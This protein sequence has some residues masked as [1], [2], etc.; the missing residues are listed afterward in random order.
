MRLSMW[1]IVDILKEYHPTVNIK[2][3]ERILRNVR[4][5]SDN[6]AISRSTVYLS[7]ISDKEILCSNEMDMVICKCRDLIEIFNTLMD[8]FEENAEWDLHI[9]DMIAD[10]CSL[11]ELLSEGAKR[12]QRYFFCADAT[13]Y[14]YKHCGDKNIIEHMP[15]FL[16]AVQ[17]NMLPIDT[18][19]EINQQKHIR[20]PNQKSYFIGI[21]NNTLISIVSNL[22]LR[23]KHSGWLV[24]IAQEPCQY[25]KG[26]CDQQDMFCD[27]VNKWMIQNESFQLQLE[28]NDF[29]CQIIDGNTENLRM[30]ERLQTFGWMPSC[31]KQIY[32]I[33]KI[34]FRLE[35]DFIIDQVVSRLFQTDFVIHYS[36]NILILVNLDSGLAED[37]EKRFLMELKKLGYIGSRSPLFHNIYELRNS[38]FAAE[39]T[40]QYARRNNLLFAK[41]EEA[42][43]PYTIHLI[44]ENTIVD[45]IHPAIY[46]LKTYDQLNSTQLMHTLDVFLKNNCSYAETTKNLFIHRST[47]LYR[48]ERIVQL[49]EIVLSDYETRFHLQ[50]SFFLLYLN[51]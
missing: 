17:N 50:L 24:S 35:T 38:Y 6:I 51:P 29:I 12:F 11:E 7:P 39:V 31:P 30:S 15:P 14:I 41:F 34:N 47:L 13:F 10:N 25:T 33:Q 45:I 2:N 3:G 16:Y 44:A 26:D 36:G 48:I 49:T 27:L 21:E 1:I 43:L 8:A 18:L 19:I 40:L 42:I 22:F 5:L 20:C 28:K 9:Q 32:L 37:Y 23:D 46:Q 4:I